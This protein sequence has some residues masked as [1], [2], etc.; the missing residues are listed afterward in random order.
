MTES[1]RSEYLGVYHN[2]SDSS[3]A[4]VP[5]RVAI[6]RMFNGQPSW[7]NLGYVKSEKVAARIYNMYAV[8]FFGKGAILNDVKNDL[9]ELREFD[10]FIH[11]EGKPKRKEQLMTARQKALAIKEGGHTFRM[12]TEL[13]QNKPAPAAVQP[14][15]EGVV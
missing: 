8:N 13:E 9:E 14:E 6:K 12:H 5:Y 10:A 1:T 4:E 7:T 2:T 15:L 3:K 11:T